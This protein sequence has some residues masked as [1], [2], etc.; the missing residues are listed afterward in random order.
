MAKEELLEFWNRIIRQ[1]RLTIHFAERMDAITKSGNGF[2]VK[3][4]KN[5]YKTKNVL[6]AIGRRGT[7][8]KLGVPGEEQPKVVYRLV[9]A[10]QYRGQQILVVGSGDSAAGCAR[11]SLLRGLRVERVP[12]AVAEQVEGEHGEDESRPREREVPP[13]RV[14]D[15]GGLGDHLAP[16]RLGR[17]DADAEV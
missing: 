12:D 2:L 15:G 16:A 11:S 6:L 10:E 13:G 17:V 8:R 1:T 3:T 14:E 9:D 4:T 5:Q 7:P